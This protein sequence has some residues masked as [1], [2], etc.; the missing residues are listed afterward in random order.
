MKILMKKYYIYNK[1]I[2]RE[3]KEYYKDEQLK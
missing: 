1:I 2:E 3:Y